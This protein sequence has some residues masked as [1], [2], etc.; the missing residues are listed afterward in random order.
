[1]KI[2]TQHPLKQIRRNCVEC[3]GTSDS[4]RFCASIDCKLWYLRFGKMPKTL[5]RN[6]KNFKLLFDKENF[7]SNQLFDPELELSSLNKHWTEKNSQQT[8]S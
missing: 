6:N 7:K 8:H 1:M 3:C 2:P 4:V 5:I